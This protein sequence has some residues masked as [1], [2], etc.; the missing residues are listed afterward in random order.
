MDVIESVEQLFTAPLE[1]SLQDFWLAND[2]V[3]QAFAGP[4]EQ[5]VL[6]GRYLWKGHDIEIMKKLKIWRK[7][8][9]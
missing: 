3:A 7:R 1:M 8:E 6:C 4:I 9:N 2:A 5:P